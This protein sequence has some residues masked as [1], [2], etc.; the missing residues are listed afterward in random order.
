MPCL[1]GQIQRIKE[2]Q[3]KQKPEAGLGEACNLIRISSDKAG[4]ANCGLIVKSLKCLAGAP[5]F[6]PLEV[7]GRKF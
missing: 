5:D 4:L 2:K 7:G 6:M 3:N 1:M